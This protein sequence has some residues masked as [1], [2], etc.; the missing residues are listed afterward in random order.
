MSSTLRTSKIIRLFAPVADQHRAHRPRGR[1][2]PFD[3]SGRW[4]REQ[5]PQRQSLRQGTWLREYRHGRTGHDSS[6]FTAVGTAGFGNRSGAVWATHFGFSG[7]RA[8]SV[9]KT[10]SG[11]AL[12]GNS[13]LFSP[14]EIVLAPGESHATPWMTCLPRPRHG[15]PDGHGDLPS[16]PVSRA[17]RVLSAD[18]HARVARLDRRVPSTPSGRCRSSCMAVTRPTP[19]MSCS[20]SLPGCRASPGRHASGAGIPGASPGRKQLMAGLGYERYAAQGGDWGSFVTLQLAVADP[21]HCAGIHLNFLPTIPMTEDHTPKR[22]EF[23]PSRKQK[24]RRRL[25]GPRCVSRSTAADHWLLDDSPAACGLDRREVPHLDRPGR[26]SRHLFH[27]GSAARQHHDV[28]AHRDGPLVGAHVLRVRRWAFAT[29]AMDIGVKVT[30]PLPHTRNKEAQTMDVEAMGGSPIFAIALRG[31]AAGWP[32]RGVRGAGAVCRRRALSGPGVF[33]DEGAYGDDQPDRRRESRRQGRGHH[34]RGGASASLARK[35]AREQRMHA[36]ALPTSKRPRLPKLPRSEPEPRR[37]PSRT[38]VSSGAEFAVEALAAAAYERFGAENCLS[39]ERLK[40]SRWPRP[41]G[42]ARS[43]TGSGCWPSTCGA[44]STACS[45]RP[46]AD[47]SGGSPAHRADHVVDGRDDDGRVLGAVCRVEVRR[48]VAGRVRRAR[49]AR[50]GFRGRR[51]VPRPGFGRH[52]DRR[53]HPQPARRAAVAARCLTIISSPA[54]AEMTSTRGGDRPTTSAMCSRHCV[55]SSGS[56]RPI[57]TRSCCGPASRRCSRTSSRRAPSSTDA[58][59]R[60]SVEVPSG[61]QKVD[62]FAA[63]CLEHTRFP[64]E[65]DGIG[66]EQGTDLGYLREL[67]THW[68]DRWPQGPRRCEA[69]AHAFRSS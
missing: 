19:P 21:D 14:G 18:H 37:L 26:R 68:R 39:P 10:P 38:D 32:L 48:G 36:K 12:I 64:N 60:S 57:T 15:A 27:E 67:V 23:S 46:A 3:L 34:G 16:L 25:P 24:L 51:V 41:R 42:S 4:C 43:R 6:L 50:G 44:P 33:G 2:D 66:W 28:L 49:S 29:D 47:L 5:H 54:I 58:A 30:V 62:D 40:S 11:P 8:T 63:R 31:G 52:E 9:E 1:R 45:S 69:E 61:R 22:S 13:E 55:D 20:P 53:L 65:I 35:A 7:N 56:P 59:L 17:R